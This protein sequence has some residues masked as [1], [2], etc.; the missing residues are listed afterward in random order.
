MRKPCGHLDIYVNGGRRQPGCTYNPK[1]PVRI[2]SLKSKISHLC[3]FAKGKIIQNYLSMQVTVC[4]SKQSFRQPLSNDI[5]APK[6]KVACISF[7]IG[8]T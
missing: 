7:F 6:E 1:K 8:F 3:T 5:S 2:H 4:I